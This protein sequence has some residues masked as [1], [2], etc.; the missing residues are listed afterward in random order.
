MIYYQVGDLRKMFKNRKA[1]TLITNQRSSL[2]VCTPVKA[3]ENVKTSVFS[4]VEIHAEDGGKNKQHHGKV[5]NYHHRS[6]QDT[7]IVAGNT[8]KNWWVK[9]YER[10]KTQQ[11]KQT[12]KQKN[13]HTSN[14]S[15]GTVTSLRS[16][17]TLVQFSSKTIDKFDHES[18]QMQI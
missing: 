1:I 17:K 3:A 4:S 10:N 9:V 14:D 6:L 5:K 13:K 11:N 7:E 18:A 16:I 15:S 8:K 12:N 2:C